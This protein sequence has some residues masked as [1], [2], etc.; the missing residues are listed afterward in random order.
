MRVQG[1]RVCASA[2]HAKKSWSISIYL[3]ARY[4][5]PFTRKI[6]PTG[7]EKHMVWPH[8]VFKVYVLWR[9]LKPESW[10]Y[11][12]I[13]SAFHAELPM[14]WKDGDGCYS[15][16]LPSVDSYNTFITDHLWVMDQSLGERCTSKNKGVN[17]SPAVHASNKLEPC[18]AAEI[19]L[20][21]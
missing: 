11:L 5:A 7:S 20:L 10:H 8:G 14:N 15:T 9:L 2:M 3:Q 6:W 19:P 17:V 1:G 13:A 18:R 4:H 12:Q 16:K 21:Q